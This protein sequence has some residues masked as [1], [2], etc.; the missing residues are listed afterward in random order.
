MR[1]NEASVVSLSAV[2]FPRARCLLPLAGQLLGAGQAIAPEQL[3]PAYLRTEV[4]KV[5]ASS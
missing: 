2:H 5:P 3:Q 4:A 1:L